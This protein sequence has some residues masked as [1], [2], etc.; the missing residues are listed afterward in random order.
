M[1]F[2]DAPPQ[3]APLTSTD[4]IWRASTAA[5]PSGGHGP[6]SGSP[7]GPASGSASGSLSGVRVAV[8]DLFALAGERIGAGN[9]D[10]L[11]EAA[12]EREHAEAV[13]LLLE[14]GAEV[15]GIAQTD[16]FAFSLGGTNKHYGTPENVAAPGCVPGGSSSGPA[17]AVA[18][19]LADLGL[20]TDTA[21]SIRVPASYCGLYGIRTTHGAVSTRGV[22]PLAPSFDTVGLLARDPALLG[23]AARVL[24]PSG[25]S[26]PVRE[27]L[28]AVDLL[29]S[30]GAP[31]RS[32]FAAAAQALSGRTGLPVRSVPALCDGRLEAWVSAFRT[33]Q[34]GEAWAAHGKWIDAHPGS[35]DA[36]IAA[37]FAAG[38]DANE[39]PEILDEARENLA[40]ARE[41]LRERIPPGTA[42]LLPASSTAALPRDLPPEGAET[43]RAGTLRLTCLASL[44]GLP[45]VVEPSLRV[46][47][48]PAGLCLAGAPDADLA[49]LALLH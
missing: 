8:K 41:T 24:L 10:W 25:E 48:K 12:P 14:A 42:L 47:G 35:L 29:D 49:L 31:M 34:S 18:A 1:E 20:G 37:R 7:S 30:L 22:H 28:V 32:A 40:L 27:L 39:R 11:A 23:T 44:A 16:E 19:G 4:G 33:V 2:A 46:D 6:L 45:A 43:V 9:P 17:A 5:L 13:R 38:R 15:A 36:P 21:G 3:V 26:E